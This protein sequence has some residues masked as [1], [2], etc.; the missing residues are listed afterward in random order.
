MEVG[1]IEQMIT[2]M[3]HEEMIGVITVEGLCQELVFCYFGLFHIHTFYTTKLTKKSLVPNDTRDFFI[4]GAV[5]LSLD[6]YDSQTIGGNSLHTLASSLV[7]D[8]AAGS[9]IVGH[10]IGTTLR[11]SLVERLGT[12]G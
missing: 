12:L 5:K 8:D 10:D 2:Q 9:E 1:S 6:I 4:I 3:P 7:D 11:E